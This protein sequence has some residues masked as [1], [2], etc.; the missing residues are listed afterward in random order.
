MY[1]EKSGLADLCLKP[2]NEKKHRMTESAGFNR[3]PA[4]KTKPPDSKHSLPLVTEG[5]QASCN[6][7]LDR[8]KVLK[9]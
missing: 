8:V 2:F 7:T 3:M 4:L 1:R 9:S 5:N 6:W